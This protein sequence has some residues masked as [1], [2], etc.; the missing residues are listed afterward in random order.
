[1]SHSILNMFSKQSNESRANSSCVASETN[2]TKLSNSII[3]VNSR[4]GNQ[5]F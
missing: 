2:A 4:S 3:K 1:M 5:G